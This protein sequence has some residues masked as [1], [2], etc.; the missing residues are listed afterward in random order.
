M[1]NCYLHPSLGLKLCFRP[2]VSQIESFGLLSSFSS[3]RILRVLGSLFLR[4]LAF[5]NAKIRPKVSFNGCFGH[6]LY[7]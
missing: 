4:H 7:W 6:F 5:T 2:R 3:V 1:T